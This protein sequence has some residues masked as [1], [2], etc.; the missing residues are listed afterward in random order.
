MKKILVVSSGRSD[1]FILQPLVEILVENDHFDC[2]LLLTGEHGT[3]FT[4]AERQ[5]Q[6]RQPTLHQLRIDQFHELHS[7]GQQCGVCA[8]IFNLL[9]DLVGN[10]PPHLVVLLGDRYEVMAIALAFS[11]LGVDLCHLHGGEVTTGAIDDNFRHAITKLSKVHFC[12]S[13]EYRKRLLHLG[14]QPDKVFNVGSLG[15]ERLRN[16][17]LIDKRTLSEQFGLDSKLGLLLVTYHPESTTSDRGLKS[18]KNLL[19]CLELLSKSFNIIFTRPCR[20]YGHLQLEAELNYSIEKYNNIRLVKNIT[21]EEYVSMMAS[22]DVMI[23]NSSSGIIEAPSFQLPVVNIGDRQKGRQ[24]AC[25]II[26]SLGDKQSIMTA[27]STAI[28]QEFRVKLIGMNSPFEGPG[29]QK[30]VDVLGSLSFPLP[31]KSFNDG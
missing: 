23:G 29:R 7:I 14:E 18:F 1:F 20:E 21:F 19:S 31:P 5:I 24:R 2:H 30:I 11:I 4:A 9:P 26:D 13:E 27:I 6:V 22:A 12:A 10:D 28:S 25:N 8:E 16:T 15:V 3:N 17:A